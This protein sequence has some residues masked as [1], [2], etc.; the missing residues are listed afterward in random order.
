MFH[1]CVGSHSGLSCLPKLTTL[2]ISRNQLATPESIEELTAC[3]EL[4][5]LNLMANQLATA[6]CYTVLQ[7][8]PKLT[9]L[10]L[11]GNPVVAD[12]KNYRKTLICMLDRLGYLDDSPVFPQDRTWLGFSCVSASCLV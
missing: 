10:Q 3:S 2:D 5:S 8:V 7:R 11:K 6:E 12:T 4:S 1:W 9:S